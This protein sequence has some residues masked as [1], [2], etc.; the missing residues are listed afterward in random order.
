M[1]SDK[2]EIKVSCLTIL[3]GHQRSCNCFCDPSTFCCDQNWRATAHSSHTFRKTPSHDTRVIKKEIASRCPHI[4]AIIVSCTR[5]VLMW[6]VEKSKC[7]QWAT[8]PCFL[9]RSSFMQECKKARRMKNARKRERT[10]LP[11]NIAWASRTLPGIYPWWCCCNRV[12]HTCHTPT[13]RKVNNHPTKKSK[14]EK[15]ELDKNGLLLYGRERG[16][17]LEFPFFQRLVPKRYICTS[18]QKNM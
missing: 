4:A 18:S 17:L 11:R 12:R 16:G 5:P 3:S 13:P 9:F 15:K 14:E 2:H 7:R 1:T 10:R 6:S 8:A